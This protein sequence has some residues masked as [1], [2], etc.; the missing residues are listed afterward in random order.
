MKS[1]IRAQRSALTQV[2]RGFTLIE[3]LTVIAII[4]VLAAII[5]P[6]FGAVRENA[7]RASC[8]SNMKNIFVLVEA[9]RIG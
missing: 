9:V 6:V 7:R 3:L 5:F 1:K 4:A 8:M 2:K